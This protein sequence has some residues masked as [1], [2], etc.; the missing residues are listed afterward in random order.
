M[1][2]TLS[3]DISAAVSE[4]GDVDY[5]REGQP[6]E[7]LHRL[8]VQCLEQSGV[9]YE[10]EGIKDPGRIETGVVIVGN[11]S[12]T[13]DIRD[14]GTIIYL[15]FGGNAR[16]TNPRQHW[17]RA[18]IIFEDESELPTDKITLYA[19][20]NG[21]HYPRYGRTVTRVDARNKV[22][23]ELKSGTHEGIMDEGRGKLRDEL[24]GPR[25]AQAIRILGACTVD[26]ARTGVF[27][28]LAN[29]ERRQYHPMRPAA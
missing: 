23:A 14:E 6:L 5:S 17:T 20:R 9:R 3:A 13:G 4:F 18:S 2:N 27:G 19:S 1:S 21:S 10:L 24:A 8:V 16:T 29:S 15:Q 28:L 11:A 25:V 26:K 22:Q 12:Q 7:V